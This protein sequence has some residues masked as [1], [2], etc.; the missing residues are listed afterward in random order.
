MV[1]RPPDFEEWEL[2]RTDRS[3][4]VLTT[5]GRD[6]YPHSVPVGLRWEDGGLRFQ[7]DPDSS[8]IRNLKRDPRV[9]VVFHGKPK[10]GVVVSGTAHILSER[11]GEQTEVRI[12]PERKR[13]WKRK[14]S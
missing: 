3:L 13:S 10:W 11:P 1:R 8:K 2:E 9:T 12:V 7:S 5:N 4:G 6:G 14:E